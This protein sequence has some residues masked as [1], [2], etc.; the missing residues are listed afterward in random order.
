MHWFDV[1][2]GAV[3]AV[4]TVVLVVVTIW[5][6]RLTRASAI[7]ARESADAARASVEEM[8]QQRR[9]NVRPVLV[10]SE[11][12]LRSEGD[13]A[14]R[15]YAF[16]VN[17]LNVG[18]FTAFDVRLSVPVAELTSYGHISHLKPNDTPP[19]G[20][21]AGTQE[22]ISPRDFRGDYV[23]TVSYRDVLGYR[24]ATIATGAV[25]NTQ[26]LGTVYVRL[27]QPKFEFLGLESQTPKGR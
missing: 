24:Y 5:Y 25:P 23:F 22:R 14:L 11:A 13:A 27:G 10:L 7:A 15:S 1:H 19:Q 4:A 8:R 3:Q 17:V 21:A 18:A 26:A 16:S 20:I 9:D 2:S 6:A 12:K